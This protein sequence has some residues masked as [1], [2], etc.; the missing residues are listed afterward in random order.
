MDGVNAMCEL[1]DVKQSSFDA[2]GRDFVQNHNIEKL[3]ES[4]GKTFYHD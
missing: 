4:V 3:A 2:V 1:R